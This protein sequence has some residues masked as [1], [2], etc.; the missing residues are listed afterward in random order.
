FGSAPYVVVQIASDGKTLAALREEATVELWNFALGR[1]LHSWQT[2]TSK[3]TTSLFAT[4]RFSANGKILGKGSDHVRIVTGGEGATAKEVRR[5]PLQPTMPWTACFS[6]DG[7]RL[8][9]GGASLQLFDV[10]TGNE[11]EALP[12]HQAMVAHLAFLSDGRTALTRGGA[13][14]TVHL[15]D[16]ATGKEQKQWLFPAQINP[17]AVAFHE[18]LLLAP[19]RDRDLWILSVATGKPVRHV[20]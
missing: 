19:G 16:V 4:A 7:S 11:I 6:P 12:G 13:E 8:A 15:W 14:N 20:S 9:V 3:D 1:L 17:I 10:A 2:H 5:W 18:D